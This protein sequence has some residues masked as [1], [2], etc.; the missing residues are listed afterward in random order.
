MAAAPQIL[1]T[2]DQLLERSLSSSSAKEEENPLEPPK[3]ILPR[4]GRRLRPVIAF[5]V[6]LILLLVGW[7]GYTFF[8]PPSDVGGL[9][10]YK[11]SNTSALSIF[12]DANS[13]ALTIKNADRSGAISGSLALS[14]MQF[15]ISGTISGHHLRVEASLN[16]LGTGIVLDG[17]VFGNNYYARL[18]ASGQPTGN[19]TLTR[20]SNPDMGAMSSDQPMLSASGTQNPMPYKQN[21][22]SGQQAPSVSATRIFGSK[23]NPKDG[24]A[25]VWVPG[26][27]FTMGSEYGVTWNEPHTQQVRL[28]G[29]WIYKYQ[30]TVAQYRAFCAEVGHALPLWPGFYSWAGKM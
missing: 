1:V 12:P 20:N 18:T 27:K 28:T 19:I 26:G 8:G 17:M 23:I 15:P 13:I 22:T 21:T 4:V 30:V 2:S 9:W 29:Y 11:L 3:Q 7:L 24:A 6:V 5:L 16:G 10:Q 14:L 25:M